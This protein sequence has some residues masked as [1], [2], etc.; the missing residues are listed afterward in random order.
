MILGGG[1]PG[2]FIYTCFYQTGAIEADRGA[3][4]ELARNRRAVDTSN[5]QPPINGAET[6]PAPEVLSPRGGTV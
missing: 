1:I 4:A 5:P 3:K 6:H 2:G